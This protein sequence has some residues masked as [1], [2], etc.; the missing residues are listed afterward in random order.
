MRNKLP[1][2]LLMVPVAFILLTFNSCNAPQPSKCIITVRDSAGDRLMVGVAV[3]LYANVSY[4]GNHIADLKA[5]GI[6]G[7]DGKV[8]FTF[9]NP[10]VM[11]VLATVGSCTVS[12]GNHV[13]CNGSGIVKCEE[14]KTAEK[15]IRI[16]H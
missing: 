13:Y 6:T 16:D 11:D 3:H 15:T 12:A 5:D 4:N 1:A 9:K 10:C 2:F 14:G 8:A 7:S